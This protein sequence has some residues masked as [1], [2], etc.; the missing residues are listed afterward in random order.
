MG[1]TAEYL[2][3]FSLKAE[4]QDI[5]A[6]IRRGLAE[7]RYT[8]NGAATKRSDELMITLMSE[9]LTLPS[10]GAQLQ[11]GLGFNGSLVNKGTF[12]VC[13]VRSSGPPRRITI[14]ATAA[15]MNA[16][17]HGADV[18]AIKS[19]S[20]D[21]IT[22]GDLVRTVA[23]DNGLTA[24][25][26]APLAG[27]MLPWVVQSAESDAALLSRLAS[28]YGA[29]SKPTNGYWLFLAYGAGQ[30]AGGKDVPVMTITPD[31]VSDWSYQEGE[32]TGATGNRKGDKSGRGKIGVN[33]FS[34]SDGRTVEHATEVYGT[35]R[36]NPFTLP[37]RDSARYCGEAKARRVSKSGRRMSLRMPC[38]SALLS[39]GAET[40]F[41]TQGF[42]VREDHNWQA[43]SVE[44]SLSASGGFSL[45]LS[46]ATDIS[47]KGVKAAEKKAQKKGINYFG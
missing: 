39:A 15:P 17:R 4:G 34:A 44:F 1:V 41:I 11:L 33:Y 3:D 23:E 9:T 21:N 22:I 28:E 29:T 35:D 25:V 16:A 18:T 30:S 38:R 12:T 14:Y 5:T 13:Q 10:K 24:R 43:E 27:I 7:I 46:L 45:S 42:G 2:P 32:R 40:R 36:L 26:S 37:D 8:D 20:F 19:R 47:P 6:A 31:M